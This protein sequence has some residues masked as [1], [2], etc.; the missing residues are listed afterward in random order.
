MRYV[1]SRRDTAITGSVILGM[2]RRG[3]LRA[4]GATTVT[5]ESLLTASRA[6]TMSTTP[7]ARRSFG[8]LPTDLL[9]EMVKGRAVE[10]KDAGGLWQHPAYG[11][12][13]IQN[14]QIAFRDETAP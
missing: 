13:L 8:L 6:R 4:Q 1:F 14:T 12:G 2:V 9:C 7:F 5:A 3:D 10:L 11:L